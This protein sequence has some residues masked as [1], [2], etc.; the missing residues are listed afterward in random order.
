MMDKFQILGESYDV[1]KS[2]VEKNGL[3]KYLASQLFDWIYV[4]K[5]R[6]FD[7][8]TNISSKNRLF[9]QENASV[10]NSLPVARS[11]STDG[12]VKY[13]FKT[14]SNGYVEAVYIPDGKRAT[15]CL[16]TQAGCKMNCAFCMTGRTGFHSDLASYDIL[17]QIF[18]IDESEKLTNIVFMGMGEPMDNLDNVL[19]SLSVITGEKGM[20]WSPKR[21]TVS[22]VGVTGGIKRF[23]ESSKCHLAISLHSADMEQR[24]QWMPAQKAWD[25]KT[26][27]KEL[28]DYDFSGQRRLSFEYIVF[29]GLNDSVMH[30]NKVIR[31]LKGLECR[32]NLIRFHSIP[33]DEFPKTTEKSIMDFEKML[34]EG[35]LR[36]TIRKS[37]G[38]DIQAA[39]GLLSSDMNKA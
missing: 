23:L 36:V 6:D 35:G 19:K 37:R 32:V 22:S 34:L 29:T 27:I 26:L 2:W 21:V 25:V 3:P 39:C 31:L 24:E 30:A 13:L 28:R 18:S 11:V 10:Y 33:G 1:V 7:E 17:N 9:L 38:E 16:S 12:T 8:M 20:A 14:Y 15:L 4:K 5:V